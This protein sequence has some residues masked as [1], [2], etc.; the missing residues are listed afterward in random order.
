VLWIDPHLPRNWTALRFPF[1]WRG[2]PLFITI[3]QGRISV[4]HRGDRPVDAQILG[5]PVRLEPD[6]RA[7][8]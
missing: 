6:R 4:E 3:E 7:D 8:F 1:V 2:Q 5:R